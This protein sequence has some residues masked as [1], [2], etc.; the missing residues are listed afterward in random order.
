MPRTPMNRDQRLLIALYSVKKIF[1]ISDIARAKFGAQKLP[2]APK[3]K[4]EYRNELAD[5]FNE[6]EP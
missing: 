4:N 1:K 3:M 6:D 5:I 2:L